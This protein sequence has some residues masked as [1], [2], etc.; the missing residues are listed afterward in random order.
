MNDAIAVF[1]SGIAGVACGMTLLYASIKITAKV[2]D[3][4]EQKK[5]AGNA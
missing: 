3:F 2:T 5:E 4:M 1:I